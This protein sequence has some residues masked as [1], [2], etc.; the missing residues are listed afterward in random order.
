MRIPLA[1]WLAML[2]LELIALLVGAIADEPPK[3]AAG[4][5]LRQSYREDAEKC[6]FSLADGEALKLVKEPIMRWTN[7]GDWSGDVFVWTHEGRPEVIGCILSGPARNNARYLWH[8]F[9][10]L[11]EKPI[12]PANIQNGRRWAPA[13]GL[14]L[15]PLPDAPPPAARATSRLV[16]MREIARGF[17]AYMWADN[18]T[19]LRLLPQPL[20]RYGDEESDVI[21]GALFSY[22]WT[23]G[24]DPELILLLECRRSEGERAWY[25]AP[26]RFSNR[27]VWLKRADKDIWGVKGHTEPAGKETTLVYTTGFARA[28]PRPPKSE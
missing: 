9:H 7:D 13:E 19:E 10:L 26:V 6:E 11:A 15:Q 8:E 21:D 3:P 5:L 1:S 18:T 22:V 28:I 27:G 2:C 14:K 4:D 16:Q 23:K 17:S 24:T 25:F 20:M 12:T